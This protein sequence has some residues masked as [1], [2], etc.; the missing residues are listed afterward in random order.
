MKRYR[1]ISM[2]N[3][4]VLSW[5]LLMFS[6]LFILFGCSNFSSHPPDDQQPGKE[7]SETAVPQQPTDKPVPS[8][9][10]TAEPDQ[11]NQQVKQTLESMTVSQK[12]GQLMLIGLE[13]TAVNSDT[14][15]MLNNKIGG[16]ILYKN[17]IKSAEQAWTLLNDLK[18]RNQ[19]YEIPL[20]LGVDQEGGKVSRMPE[21]FIKIPS[22]N[23]VGSKENPDYAYRTGQ[24]I[25]LEVSSLGFNFDFA[26]VLD[27]NSN[28]KNPVIGNRAYGTT[29]EQ[30]ARYALEAMKGIQSEQVATSVKH[31]P[32]HGDT[33]VDSHR[34][35]PVIQKSKSELESFETK[36]FVEAIAE[37]A[38]SIMVGH[39]LIPAIDE[40]FP[41]SLSEKIVTDW[42][43]SELDYDGVIITDDMTMGGITKHRDIAEAALQSILAG[44]DIV[45]IGHDPKLQLKV[46][47]RLNQ[48][49]A[50]GIL[51]EERINESVE[52]ILTLKQKYELS[53]EATPVLDVAELNKK[54]DSLLK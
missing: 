12:I 47:D 41:A 43:R 15:A 40:E 11:A 51:T 54:V 25:G 46:W 31:F 35:L 4:K 9:A 39:L 5:I 19:A 50:D 52:R 21:D 16:F 32:G 49:A 26:P 6:C 27:I 1:P 34:D 3:S 20:W 42:L 13:G 7:P 8:A 10:S 22:P 38:D 14:E 29:P 53:D 45:L 33:T 24:A 23:I 18:H 36:P 28:P 48:A 30:A 2:T 17:N 44:T 37:N